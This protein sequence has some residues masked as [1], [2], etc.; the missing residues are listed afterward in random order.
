MKVVQLHEETKNKFPNLT[1]TP[2][3]AYYGQKNSKMTQKLIQNQMSECEE[4]YKMKVFNY[5]SRPKNS[6]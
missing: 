2:K 5:M 3:I 1:A 6:C 4:T